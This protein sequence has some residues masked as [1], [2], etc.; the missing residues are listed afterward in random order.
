MTQRTYFKL[1]VYSVLLVVTVIF[2]IWWLSFNNSRYRDYERLGDLKVIQAVM[3]D[4]FA[5]FNT[6]DIPQCIVGS[7]INTCSG[8]DFGPLAALGLKD[9]I[10]SG[11][12]RYVMSSF[13]ANDFQ[14]DFSFENN[15][16]GLAAGRHSLTQSGIR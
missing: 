10:N 1:S 6:Y 16:S 7:A 13:S 8:D 14:I 11:S 2:Y 4:Y 9:P 3:A 12:Y 15:I 5:Q